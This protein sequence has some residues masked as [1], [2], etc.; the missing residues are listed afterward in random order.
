MKSSVDLYCANKDD[1][2]VEGCAV[3]TDASDANEF[4]EA[5]ADALCRIFKIPNTKIELMGGSV[6]EPHKALRIWIDQGFELMSKLK[7]YKAERVNEKRVLWTGDV[8]PYHG[9][10]VEHGGKVDEKA[11]YE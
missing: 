2:A 7:G 1:N 6:P 11:G 8:P 5:F 3:R 9:W 10:H 4:A